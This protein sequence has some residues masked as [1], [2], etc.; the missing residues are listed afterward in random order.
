MLICETQSL[1]KSKPR[2][3]SKLETIFRKEFFSWAKS[4]GYKFLG[5][6]DLHALIAFRDT[7]IDG[8]PAKRKK[9]ERLIGFFDVRSPRLHPGQPDLWT[10]KIKLG[11]RRRRFS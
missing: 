3:L 8:P 1:G 7:W 11:C 5:E 10:R 9:Q 4:E 6:I 2:T